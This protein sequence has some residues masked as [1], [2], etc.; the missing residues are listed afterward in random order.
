M[1]VN[2]WQDMASL[3]RN[4]SLSRATAATAMNPRSS[5]S[6]VIFSVILEQNAKTESSLIELSLSEY[7]GDIK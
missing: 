4:G 1:E 6:H 5:R 3:I 2:S 7:T